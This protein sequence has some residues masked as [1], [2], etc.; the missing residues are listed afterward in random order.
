MCFCSASLLVASQSKSLFKVIPHTA[1]LVALASAA[2]GYYLLNESQNLGEHAADAVSTSEYIPPSASNL[3]FQS[4]Y[5][6]EREEL[7]YGVQ[8]VAVINALPQSLLVW[9]FLLFSLSI[10]I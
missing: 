6:Q 9:A 4:L 2:S 7:E 3:V 8:H 1:L 10:L 5:F